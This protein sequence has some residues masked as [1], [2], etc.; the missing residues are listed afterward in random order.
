M[1][2]SYGESMYSHV[3]G[4]VSHFELLLKSN[5][6]CSHLR[7]CGCLCYPYIRPYSTTKLDLRFIPCV[8]F[9]YPSH[10]EGYVHL[11]QLLRIYY[12][13]VVFYKEIFFKYPTLSNQ[14]AFI[15]QINPILHLFI[16]FISHRLTINT[17]P[18]IIFSNLCHVCLYL[19]HQSQSHPLH[20][21]QFPVH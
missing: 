18:F 6:T 21:L 1:I 7:M 2:I 5:P 8:F 9:C 15:I 20:P 11:D 19:P 16:L 10:Q 4:N 17:K 12:S 14:L 3:L 13:H